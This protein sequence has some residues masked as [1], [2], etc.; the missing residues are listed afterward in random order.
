MP[1]RLFFDPT[2][3]DHDQGPEHPESPAR[4]EAITA[5]LKRAPIAGVEWAAP[6]RATRTELLYAHEE[7]H[8]ERV[9]GLAGTRARLDPDT[10]TSPG[11]V[12]A[13]VLAAGAAAQAVRDVMSGAATNAFALVRPPGHHA[14][15]TRAMGFCLFNNVAVAAGVGRALGAQRVMIVDWDVHHGNGTQ[16]RF[17]ARKD[18]LFASVHQF[19]FYPGTGAPMEIGEGE[20]RGFTVNCALPGGQNDAD[21]GAV[22]E[23]VFVPLAQAYRPDLVLVSAGYDAHEADPLGGMALTER[24]YAAMTSAVMAMAATAGHQKVVLLLEGGYDL[25]ALAA[26]VHASVEVLAGQ[27]KDDFPSGAS[28]VTD[29]NLRYT[30]AALAPFWKGTIES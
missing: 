10:A 25:E 20:G 11:S 7:S 19:P 12:D 6:P 14:E 27:R 18:V 8:V 28:K 4:L 3:L 21:Y 2:F 29:V 16:E 5:E 26:S 24:A 22:F 30:Q 9:L 13:A 23:R 15:S 17:L 1:T